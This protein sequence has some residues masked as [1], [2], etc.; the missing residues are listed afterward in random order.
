MRRAPA[1]ASGSQAR[2]YVEQIGGAAQCCFDLILID[3]RFRNACA[4]HA[5]RLSH[6]HTV[7]LVHDNERYVGFGSKPTVIETYYHAVQKIDSLAVLRPKP[8]ALDMVKSAH[9]DSK[10]RADRVSGQ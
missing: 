3:G 6:G 9:N 10:L 1:N 5:L 4:L 7:V 8:W 2:D